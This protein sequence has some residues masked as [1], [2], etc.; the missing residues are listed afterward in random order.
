[1]LLQCYKIVEFFRNLFIIWG[2]I[3]RSFGIKWG[4]GWGH[5]GSMRRIREGWE[6]MMG[7]NGSKGGFEK[8]EE[9][10]WI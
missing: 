2:V 4:I 8:A 3:I 6:W 5:L 7:L 10:V 1:M 9:L